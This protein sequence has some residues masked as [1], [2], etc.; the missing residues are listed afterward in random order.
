VS[1]VKALYDF[2]PSESGEL[3]FSRGD[4]ITVLDSVYKD[5]WRGE[6][7]GK[8]GIFPVNYVVSKKS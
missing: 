5:W 8:T 4:V 6:L 7:H 2:V 1:K 3:G